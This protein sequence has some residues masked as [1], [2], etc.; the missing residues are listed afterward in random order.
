MAPEEGRGEKDKR[1]SGFS[2]QCNG[3]GEQQK[4]TDGQVTEADCLSHTARLQLMVI[5]EAGDVLVHCLEQPASIDTDG[6]YLEQRPQQQQQ[7]QGVCTS[8]VKLP[9]AE[10]AAA[11]AA[12]SG[13]AVPP[14]GR[15]VCTACCWVSEQVLAV[16]VED[17]NAVGGGFAPLSRRRLSV[18]AFTLC[19]QMKWHTDRDE[20]NALGRCAQ[21]HLWRLPSSRWSE[22][23]SGGEAGANETSE[24]A[25]LLQVLRS[26]Q[27]QVR[28][29]FFIM[30][31]FPTI[32]LP[33][34][35]LPLKPRSSR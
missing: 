30:T 20:R 29:A 9:L 22:E 2:T 23:S 16:G 15:T 28:V 19:V 24:P 5:N 33:P 10:A 26:H 17:S 1:E 8:V 35:L 14:P 31:W 3:K 27:E 6:K 11:L 12:A 4:R 34:D 13:A 32:P 21:V 25:V 7:R 18:A